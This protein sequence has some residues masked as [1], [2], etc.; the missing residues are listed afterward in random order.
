MSS[1][2]SYLNKLSEEGGEKESLDFT[3]DEARALQK[4]SQSQLPDQSLWIV[5][6]VQAAVSGEASEV[7]IRLG[8]N[9]LEVRFDS[10]KLPT[11]PQLFDMVRSGALP[12]DPFFLHLLTGI[13]TSFAGEGVSFLLQTVG[14][15]GKDVIALSEGKSY[16][17]QEPEETSPG[18]TLTYVIRRPYRMLKFRKALDRPVSQ[19]LKGTAAEH[20]ELMARCWPSPIPVRIDGRL[21]DTRYDSPLMFWGSTTHFQRNQ[22]QKNP[23]VTPL[24]MYLRYY[25]AEEGRP[26]LATDCFDQGERREVEV[27]SGPR[28]F[29]KKPVFV[30]GRFLEW[31]F[32]EERAGKVLVSPIGNGR[33]TAIYFVQD[34]V[35]VQRVPVAFQAPPKVL[36]MEIQPTKVGGDCLIVPVT[37]EDLDLSQFSVSEAEKRRHELLNWIFKQSLE[38]SDVLL[39]LL[40]HF[41]AVPTSERS[42]KRALAVAGAAALP[43]GVS[44]G[45][46]GLLFYSFYQGFILGGALAPK[47]LFIKAL[48]QAYEKH[49]EE[50]ETHDVTTVEQ[51]LIE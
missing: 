47:A 39:P 45:G 10:A 44:F 1:I 9:K 19:L 11:A 31:D 33:E 22:A 27:T 25:P 24:N 15:A 6:M 32:E 37:F 35:L 43:V 41:V 18:L 49:R 51:P 3:L 26:T 46:F 12:K 4:L 5:K 38:C 34:G 40:K 13:R 48:K 20:L 21:L 30:H 14:P 7:D 28:L 17:F 16:H 42:A 2:D 29:L 50:W 23:M 8:R 36:G